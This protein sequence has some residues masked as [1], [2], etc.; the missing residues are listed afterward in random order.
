MGSTCAGAE[1]DPTERDAD[2]CMEEA[3]FDGAEKEPEPAPPPI[4]IFGQP[5]STAT[6]WGLPDGTQAPQMIVR[7]VGWVERHALC[8]E[9]LYRVSPPPSEVLH[10]L[11]S[12]AAAELAAPMANSSGAAVGGRSNQHNECRG[13]G[14]TASNSC[15]HVIAQVPR[16]STHSSDRSGLPRATPTAC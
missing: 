16:S 12:A 1:K 4:P 13:T 10:L 7:A 14:L 5:L 2:H 3:S 8:T 15:H 6:M 11:T 9:G